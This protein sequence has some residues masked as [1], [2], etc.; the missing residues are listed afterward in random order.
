MLS[1]SRIVDRGNAA[2]RTLEQTDWQV[3]ALQPAGSTLQLQST[4]H[5][6]INSRLIDSDDAVLYFD[7]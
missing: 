4:L 6:P 5:D 1:V 3:L 2:P 7:L